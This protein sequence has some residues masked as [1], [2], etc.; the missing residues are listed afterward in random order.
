MPLTYDL[1]IVPNISNAQFSGHV[2]IV[3]TIDN[4]MR[5]IRLHSV[6]LSWKKTFQIDGQVITL[7]RITFDNISGKT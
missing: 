1:T 3:F 6:G 5:Y 4:P 7:R 2:R